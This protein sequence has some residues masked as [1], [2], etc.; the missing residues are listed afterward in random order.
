MPE[1]AAHVRTNLHHLKQV[2]AFLPF[3]NPTFGNPAF[4]G[5]SHRVLIVR[6]SPFR[7]VD[8]SIPHLFLFQEVRRALPQAFIDMAFFP[9]RSARKVFDRGNVPYL[10]GVQSLRPADAF[11]LVLISNA[12]TLEL[13][14]LPY[15]LLHSHI[16]LY[17]SQRGE[18][19]P[20]MILGGSNAMAAQAIVCPDGDSLVDG[21]FVGEGEGR[22]GS[23]VQFLAHC[24]HRDRRQLLEEAATQREGF[25]AAGSLRPTR[26]AVL[27][28][29]ETRLLPVDYPLLNSPEAHTANLQITYGCPAFCS[30]CFEGYDR[31]PY[32][33]IPLPDLVSAARQ[34]KHAQGAEELNLYSFNFNA[35]EDIMALLLEL[36]ALFDR[37]S[38]KSQR[39]DILQ[40]TATLLQ[41]EVEADKRSYTLGIEGISARQRAW[42]HKSLP[43]E[44]IVRLLERLFTH[45]IR[46]V[47]LF[48]VLTGTETEEDITEF[49]QFLRKLKDVRRSR[50]RGIRVI[51][52]FGLLIRMPFTPLRYDRLHLD[53]EAWRPL[54]GQAK[55]A[56]ETNGF[57]FRLAFDWPTYCATQVLALGGHW[58]VGPVV[59]MAR[60]GH[61]FED[62]LPP[63]Y[64]E[65]LRAWMVREGRWNEAFLGEKGPDYVFPMEHVQSDIGPEF[66]YRQYQEALSGRDTGYCLG[67]RDGHGRC[68]GCGA[69]LDQEERQTIMRHRLQ[70]PEGDSYIARLQETMSRKHRLQPVYCRIRLGPLVEGVAPAF[71]N[72]FVFR[73]ILARYPELTDNLLSVRESLFTHPLNDRRFPTMSGETVCALKAWDA[74][75]LEHALAEPRWQAGDHVRVIQ[76]AEGFVPGTFTRLHLDLHLP[77]EHFSEPRRTLE[78]YL[79]DAYLPY[80]L[81]REGNRYRFD[82]P[83]KGLKKKVVLGGWFEASEEGFDA[84]LDI[85]P[86]FDLMAFLAGFGEYG[87]FRYTKASVSDIEW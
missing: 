61:V 32:R 51:F 52:S 49:R 21:I 9:D 39:V 53:E 29:P 11:D 66:L 5:A 44:D 35:H 12:Y 17:S 80:S 8:R 20:F 86:R 26:K 37:V 28:A 3:D 87:L 13:I 67:G 14:N 57:E 74:A 50:N 76:L 54:I 15:L 71:L 36:H 30:F 59:E 4:E 72:A 63:I 68:L 27:H 58:L 41:A 62:T 24:R 82:V 75:S 77:A 22:T 60:K 10:L 83:N 34:L 73:E 48:Y 18:E 25:W 43:T 79:R 46:E 47:K 78:H 70:A 23:L 33:E 45:K 81:R 85:G 19:W 69:C 40:H 65:E 6:L 64:W 16:P 2:E 42:L 7:D 56:C 38:F 55:S 84:S 31:K 1:H